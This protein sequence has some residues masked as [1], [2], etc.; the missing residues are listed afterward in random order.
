MASCESA[1]CI[2]GKILSYAAPSF[3]TIPITLLVSVHVITHYEM[4]GAK[5][6]YISL[7][8]AIGGAVR[9]ILHSARL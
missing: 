5:L 9:S 7:F 4:I 8:V 2:A 1:A 6:S 3:S